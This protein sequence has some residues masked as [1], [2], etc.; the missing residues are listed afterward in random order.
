MSYLWSIDLGCNWQLYRL[1]AVFSLQFVSACHPIRWLSPCSSTNPTGHYEA[2]LIPTTTATEAFQEWFWSMIPCLSHASVSFRQG[3]SALLP[4]Y[5]IIYVFFYLQATEM[6]MSCCC[7]S[8]T[9]CMLDSQIWPW[10]LLIINHVFI[11]VLVLE[12]KML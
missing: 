9:C 6:W 8:I 12:V 11:D 2:G 5:S 4:S 7:R 1:C 10:L 3:Y